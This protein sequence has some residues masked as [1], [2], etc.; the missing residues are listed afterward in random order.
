MLG[1]FVV[2]FARHSVGGRSVSSCFSL[3]PARSFGSFVVFIRST[4]CWCWVRSLCFSID[5][6]SEFGFVRRFDDDQSTGSA[7]ECHCR[8]TRG[9]GLRSNPTYT[10]GPTQPSN[11]PRSIQLN[12]TRRCGQCATFRAICAGCFRN[13]WKIRHSQFH[14]RAG[15]ILKYSDYRGMSQD[16]GTEPVKL[17]VDIRQALRALPAG[18]HNARWCN[19]LYGRE[20]SVEISLDCQIPDQKRKGPRRSSMSDRPITTS[21][22]GKIARIRHR[23][24]LVDDVRRCEAGSST[25]ARQSCIGPDNLGRPLEVK[26]SKSRRGYA[27]GTRCTSCG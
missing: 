17:G 5:V 15:T 26:S 10:G 14:L 7:V 22:I 16:T 4:V 19:E 13:D 6:A 3:D 8:A 9:R 27:A 11:L 23:Q 25:I 1:S 20:K 2:F 18:S 21:D 24:Y 12:F